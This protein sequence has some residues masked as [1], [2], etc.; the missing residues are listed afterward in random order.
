MVT[1]PKEVAKYGMGPAAFNQVVNK[2][3]YLN[4]DI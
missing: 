1:D 3:V 2:V 4:V